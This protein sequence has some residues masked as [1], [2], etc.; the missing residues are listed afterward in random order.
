MTNEWRWLPV[1]TAALAVQSA[2]ASLKRDSGV[3]SS[4]RSEGKARKWQQEMK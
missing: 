2:S 1:A 3:V 4:F